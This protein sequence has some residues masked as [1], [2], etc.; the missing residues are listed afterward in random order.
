MLVL[1]RKADETILIG[2]NV[3][4]VVVSI[5]GDKVRLGFNLPNSISVHRSE[6]AEKILGLGLVLPELAPISHARI[7]Q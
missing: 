3:E 6:V 2:S 5:R 4:I 7:A 1:S